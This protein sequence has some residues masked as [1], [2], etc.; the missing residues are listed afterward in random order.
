MPAPEKDNVQVRNEII[1]EEIGDQPLNLD[2]WTT[3]VIQYR[4]GSDST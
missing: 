2:Q 1:S 4:S 3:H